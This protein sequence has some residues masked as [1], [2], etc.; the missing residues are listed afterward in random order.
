MLIERVPGY[1]RI[2]FDPCYRIL[3]TVVLHGSV[4]LYDLLYIL[5]TVSQ[6]YLAVTASQASPSG[7]QDA[8]DGVR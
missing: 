5:I 7:Q 8:L 6:R 1:D 3:G 2:R 4:R